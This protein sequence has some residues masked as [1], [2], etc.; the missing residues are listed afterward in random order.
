MV[1][2]CSPL[3]PREHRAWRHIGWRRCREN[4][5]TERRLEWLLGPR[6]AAEPLDGAQRLLKWHG[7]MRLVEEDEAVVGREAR[8]NRCGEQAVAIAAEQ[9][10]GSELVHGRGD[11]RRL[12][13]E[14]SP[15]VI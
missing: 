12:R 10:P 1:E 8:V 4:H 13:R 15:A 6:S 7:A 5:E 9:Q 14:S 3:Q 11:D 2:Q